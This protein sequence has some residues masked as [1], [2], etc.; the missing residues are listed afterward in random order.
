MNSPIVPS[1]YW[2]VNFPV[3]KKTLQDIKVNFTLLFKGF[4]LPT[5]GMTLWKFVPVESG[6]ELNRKWFKCKPERSLRS[7]IIPQRP[8]YFVVMWCI[9]LTKNTA[10]TAGSSFPQKY[11]SAFPCSNQGSIFHQFTILK[12]WIPENFPPDFCKMKI[13][14]VLK[15]HQRKQNAGALFL[16]KLT[17]YCPPQKCFNYNLRALGRKWREK[18]DFC[19][20]GDKCLQFREACY[21]TFNQSSQGILLPLLLLS[22]NGC[23]T[24]LALIFL[25]FY[26]HKYRFWGK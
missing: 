24:T 22:K 12:W 23:N 7:C 5:A 11:I 18:E 16:W 1:R 10:P 20:E 2:T 25:S 26:P 9:K 15:N 6:I 13:I 14:L 21:W 3:S 17:M 4:L 8:I 19:S